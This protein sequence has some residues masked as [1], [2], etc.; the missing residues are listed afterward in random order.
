[1]IIALLLLINLIYKDSR[2][3]LKFYH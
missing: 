3:Q 2:Y 1:L